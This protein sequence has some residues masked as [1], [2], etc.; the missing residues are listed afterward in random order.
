MNTPANNKSFALLSFLFLLLYAILSY[1]N[2]I[3]YEDYSAFIDNDKYGIWGNALHTA[4]TWG[5][6][7]FSFL[8]AFS[9]IKAISVGI[10]QYFYHL[11]LLLLLVLG[12]KTV[13]AQITLKWSSYTSALFLAAL[14]FFNT[15]SPCDSWFWIIASTNYLL[16]LITFLF[17]IGFLL[18]KEATVV[19]KLIMALLALYTGAASEPFA[20]MCIFFC[21]SFLIYK[22]LN[23]IRL[24]KKLIVIFIFLLLGFI[25]SE[26]AP[27]TGLRKSAL[28]ETG[29]LLA[30]KRTFT[31]VIKYWLFDFYR[32]IPGF[33]TSVF[34]G[35]IFKDII[36]SHFAK[37]WAALK[38]KGNF[39]K[40]LSL[41]VLYNIIL[42]ISFLPVCIIMGEA[43]PYRSWY[44]IGVYTTLLGLLIGAFAGEMGMIQYI[45]KYINIYMYVVAL[46]LVI[47]IFAQFCELKKF[48]AAYDDRMEWLR[49]L[50]MSIH[51]ETEKI[52]PLPSSGLLQFTDIS[53]D[54]SSFQNK[55]FAGHLHLSYYIKLNRN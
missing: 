53:T 6:N 12:L 34:T 24:N 44:H 51:Y 3:V 1:Y 55:Y 35:I 13:L 20:L 36:N 29:F 14:L 43:G 31:A 2:R 46:S 8:V 11:F 54:S 50:E 32:I 4:Q 42:F 37:I 33:I 9:I 21:A 40:L 25:F 10:P 47:L 28:P 17:A 22:L 7:L 39:Q 5:G 48:A 26:L 18:K 23:N 38:I 49:A 30:L 16:A 45:Y 19:E 27:G 41:F 52:E 15:I